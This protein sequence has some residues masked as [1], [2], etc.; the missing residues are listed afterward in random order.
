MKPFLIT[1]VALLATAQLAQA[2]KISGSVQSAGKPVELATVVL[3][4]AKDSALVKGAISDLDGVFELDGINAGDYRLQVSAVGFALSYSKSLTYD[5]KNTTLPAIELKASTEKL[6]D[7]TVVAKRPMFEVKA[8]K[9]IM[10]VE[11]NVNSTG[12]NAL[13]LLRKAPGVMVDKDDNITLKGKQGVRVFIDGKP[14]Q[15]SDKD[16]A[17]LLKSMQSSNIGEIE[18]IS[19]PSAK[20]DAAGTGGIINIKLRKNK[21]VGFNGNTE[22]TYAQGIYAKYDGSVGLN[23]RNEHFNAFGSYGRW[24]GKNQNFMNFNRGQNGQYFEQKAINTDA[25]SNDNFKIGADYFINKKHTVGFSVNGN[26]SNKLDTGDSRTTISEQIGEGTSTTGSDKI[27]GYLVA[28][29][30]T[31]PNKR[32]NYN[33]NLNY[34]FAD[35]LGHELTVDADYGTFRS[36]NLS[37]Q[38]NFY[39]DK[40]GVTKPDG[41]VSFGISQNTN[42]DIKTLKADYET[43]F[44]K[45]KLGVGVKTAFVTTKNNFGYYDQAAN[46]SVQF[47]SRSFNFVYSENINA[48]YANYNRDINKKWS[49]QAGLRI[50]TTNTQG[51]LTSNNNAIDTTFKRSF[52]N[53]FF[54]SAAISYNMNAMHSFSLNYSRR[55]DRPNYQDLNPFQNKLDELTYQQGNPNLRPQFTNSVELTHTFMQF[56]NTSLSY[57]RTNDFFTEITNVL[58]STKSFVM[59][60][61]L[62][63]MDNFGLNISAPLPLAKWY[64]G[65]FNFGANFQE[66][67][68]N[69]PQGVISVNVP[70][71]NIYM[72]NTFTLGKGF[73]AELS[74]FYASPNLWGGSFRTNPFGGIDIGLQKKILKDKGMIKLALSD[75]LFTQRWRGV[76]TFGGNFFEAKG[77]WESQQARVSFSY[78]FGSD[79][80]S[81]RERKKGNESEANR[82]KGK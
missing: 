2:Q 22:L 21:K 33:Y 60:D 3:L 70:S 74:G 26:A 51:T 53:P 23:Y 56:I 79:D 59:T 54:P 5:G 1:L 42:I 69:L 76:S 20:Y 80:F 17:A 30:I 66:Y 7:V 65:F 49:V 52:P 13:D 64:N 31:K 63:Y 78:R 16:L 72:Q 44:M 9:M 41:D 24:Q 45:G 32:R 38:P 46:Q 34:R 28:T 27:Y 11:G 10:N 29:S 82:I 43:K 75:V 15:L 61:N 39:Q 25:G 47:P 67:R 19:N 58:D 18:L 4:N 6:A 68:A 36:E 73:A 50:E 62:A 71:Y 40:N 12:T 55:I 37:N 57:S 81:P 8:D 48:A 35:T 14:S 77:G